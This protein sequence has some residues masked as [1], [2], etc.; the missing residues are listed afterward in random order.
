[1]SLEQA[2]RVVAS[3]LGV[4]VDYEAV[5]SSV[6]LGELVPGLG[7]V[8][9]VGRVLMVLPVRGF[10][11]LDGSPG[12]VARLLMAD[13]TGSATVVLWDE[14][15]GV[16]ERGDIKEGKVIRILHGYTREALDGGV[17]VHVGIRG[18]LQIEPQ[19]VDPREF[20]EVAP[21]V[22]KIGELKA[23]LGLVSVV[24][25]L[26]AVGPP[27]TFTR[28]DGTTGRVRRIRIADETGFVPVVLWDDAVDAAEELEVGASLQVLNARVR[29]KATGELELHVNRAADLRRAEEAEIHVSP[30]V[31]V[32][33]IRDLKP[34]AS[35]VDVLVEV[36]R[37]GAMRTF[38]RPGGGEGRVA[39]LLVRDETGITDL[40]LWDEKAE[41]VGEVKPGDILL[42]RG[43]YT[44]ERFGRTRLNLGARGMVEVNPEIP[45]FQGFPEMAVEETPISSIREGGT[46]TVRGTIET[47]PEV[48]EVT[49]YKGRQ[50]TVA[51]FYLRDETGRIRV[52]LWRDLAEDVEALPVGTQVRIHNL[53]ARMGPF[54]LE[55]SSGPLTLLEVVGEAGEGAAL[56]EPRV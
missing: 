17:E 23:G 51:S 52:S 21:E 2:L 41:L 7:D 15:A 47:A 54:G 48:R 50:A 20:P 1:M 36:V 33:K 26:Q 40:T 46:Y 16:V 49:T 6:P 14:K 39:T 24:G 5:G 12:K 3:E 55:L 22:R 53:Y 37:V 42:V 27:S 18:E 9:V 56:G 45:G 28:P 32:R 43:A 13:R 11:R 4:K 38:P 25:V 34:G 30:L 19:D 35:D 8:T 31:G 10:R 29:E 44:R